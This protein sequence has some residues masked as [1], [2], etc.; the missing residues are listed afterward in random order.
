VKELFPLARRGLFLR[1]HAPRGFA[2]RLE[3]GIGGNPRVA[4]EQS[5]FFR[6]EQDRPDVLADRPAIEEVGTAAP[7]LNV[8]PVRSTL[9]RY[10]SVPRTVASTLDGPPLMSTTAPS[11]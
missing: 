7:T 6:L 5:A 11:R 3:L 10:G 1:G 9:T 4:V 8:F 2:R